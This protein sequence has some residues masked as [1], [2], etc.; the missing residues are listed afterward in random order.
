MTQKRIS[1]REPYLL[2]LILL[3]IVFLSG[4]GPS[5]AG[6]DKKKNE[7]KKGKKEDDKPQE[8][9]V[10]KKLTQGMGLFQL[11]TLSPDKKLLSLLA[12]K[13]GGVPNLY[14]MD[15]SNF[16]LRPALTKMKWGAVDPAWSPDS[17]TLA[18]AGFNETASFSDIYVVDV[19]TSRVR[20]V[21]ANGYT[22]KEPAFTADGKKLLFTTDE[23]P[24]EDAAFGILHIGSMP[25]SGGKKSEYFTEDEA[26]TIRP[27]PSLDGKSIYVI[28]ISDASGRHT[29]WEYDVRGKPIRDITEE[30]FARIHKIIFHPAKATAVL[31]AQEQPEQQEQV[32]LLDIKSGKVTELPEPD[33]PKR[34]PAISP[35]GS[36]IAFVGPSESGNHLYM[37]DETT[38]LIQRLTA[39]GTNIHSPV[40]IADDQII[41]GGEREG[42]KPDVAVKTVGNTT[43]TQEAIPDREIY[44]LSLSQ[45]VVDEKKKK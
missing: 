13:E 36:L 2:L 19:E 1:F 34:S 39:K 12:Q 15:V 35:N 9:Y 16:S 5:V 21:T 30:K 24:L 28:K 8:Q 18:F 11:G 25:L 44:L 43:Y 38:G 42:K 4:I 27:V 10:V 40:F 31:W 32:Y 37:Y 22:D 26:S 3:A 14:V 23:S 45:K 17:S 41:F 29:L 6:Q 7:E 33:L 20:Q